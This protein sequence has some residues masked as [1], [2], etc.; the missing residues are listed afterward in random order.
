MADPSEVTK[1]TSLG[2]PLIET[3][4]LETLGV[5]GH[6]CGLTL[7]LQDWGFQKSPYMSASYRVLVHV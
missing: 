6:F 3:F 4:S 7:W 2:H 5:N 1:L